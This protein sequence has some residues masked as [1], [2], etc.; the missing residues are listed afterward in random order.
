MGIGGKEWA[1]YVPESEA[2]ILGKDPQA[3]ERFSK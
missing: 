2:P 1:S 3:G